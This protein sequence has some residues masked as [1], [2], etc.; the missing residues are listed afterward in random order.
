ME[1]IFRFKINVELLFDVAAKDEPEAW[2]TARNALEI[3]KF[4]TEK[5]DTDRALGGL[6]APYLHFDSNDAVL[7]D[8]ELDTPSPTRVERG[9]P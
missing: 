1:K 8:V 6:L 7:V 5:G 2:N 3:A 4:H 9:N